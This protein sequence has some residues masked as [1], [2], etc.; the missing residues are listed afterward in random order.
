MKYA[1]KYNSIMTHTIVNWNEWK[2]NEWN[3]IEC[4]GFDLS[5]KYIKCEE[6]RFS[7]LQQ[8]LYMPIWYCCVHFIPILRWRQR[9]ESVGLEHLP[10]K[11]HTIICYLTVDLFYFTLFFAHH[12]IN[13]Y[14]QISINCLINR[15]VIDSISKSIYLISSQ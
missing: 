5:L 7:T 1:W 9:V 15:I 10:K 13:V 8:T 4:F 11:P 14:V 3:G 2:R 12:L 6:W